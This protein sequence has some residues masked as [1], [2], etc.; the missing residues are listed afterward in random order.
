MAG[1]CTWFD[2][3]ALLKDRSQHYLKGLL[4]TRNVNELKN[5]M[6]ESYPGSNKQDILSLGSIFPFEVCRFLA[7]SSPPKNESESI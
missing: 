3:R 1:G 6:L 2:C 5:I 7:F 4:K